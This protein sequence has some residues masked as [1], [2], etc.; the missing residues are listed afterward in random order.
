MEIQSPEEEAQIGNTPSSLSDL[1]RNND[2][3]YQNSKKVHRSGSHKE[4]VS[5]PITPK[6]SSEAKDD[7]E[8]WSD[9]LMGLLHAEDYPQ[10]APDDD[11]LL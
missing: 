9:G 1:L 4:D 8:Q 3:G 5:T 6:T 10:T 7:M 2:E 11:L